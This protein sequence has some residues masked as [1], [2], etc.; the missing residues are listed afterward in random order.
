M[1]NLRIK[2]QEITDNNLNVDDHISAIEE[3]R[4]VYLH[5]IYIMPSAFDEPLEQYNCVMHALDLAA[6]GFDPCDF[7]GRFYAN[8]EF[9]SDMIE[10]G[11]IEE[12]N[13]KNGNIITWSNNE[14]IMHVG[15]IL[16]N[17]I[18]ISKWGIGHLYKHGLHE[19]P[20][21][22]GSQINYYK[23]IDGVQCFELLC[24]FHTRNL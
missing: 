23:P 6:R 17:D 19:I 13:Q 5:S 11:H 9:L 3:I 15:L 8:T 2:L 22:Y 20:E 24:N 12:C 16:D 1:I 18:A 10:K 21:N 7:K 14:R 4:N